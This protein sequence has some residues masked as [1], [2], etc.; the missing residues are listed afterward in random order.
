MRTR[1]V[2]FSSLSYG[3]GLVLGLNN[4]REILLPAS[5]RRPIKEGGQRCLYP[6][7]CKDPLLFFSRCLVPYY[8]PAAGGGWK[9]VA[10]ICTSAS[11]G[12]ASENRLVACSSAVGRN[13][14]VTRQGRTCFLVGGI[15][16]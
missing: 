14:V 10:K 4:S 12:A 15:G 3:G 5:Q 13:K 2:L 9:K 8:P 7:Q 1:S 16:K 6:V 11:G